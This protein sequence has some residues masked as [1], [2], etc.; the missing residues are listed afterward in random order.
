MAHLSLNTAVI[1]RCRSLAESISQ[2]VEGMIHSHTTVAIERTVLRLLG[3]EGAI[4]Q[5]GGQTIPEVN[6]IV[7]DLRKAGALADGVLPL[8]VNGMIQ[9]KMT[10]R[11]L[12]SA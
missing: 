1:D 4:A 8:F 7:E 3:V 5:S 2:S 9:K 11:E 10:A 6:I 12:A